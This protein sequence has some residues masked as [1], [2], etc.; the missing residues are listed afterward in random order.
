M[1][2]LILLVLAAC[3]SSTPE[4]RS[5]DETPWVSVPTEALP[6]FEGSPPKNVLMISIDTLRKDHLSRYDPL[7]RDLTPF[8]DDLMETG[9]VLDDHQTC[10][11]WTFVGV[12]CTLAGA[13]HTEIGFIPQLEPP[14]MR[15]PFRAGQEF[16]SDWMRDAGYATVLASANG[17]LSRDWGTAAGYD[18]T[19]GVAF[20]SAQ[21]IYEGGLA[22]LQE[23]IDGGAD[24]WFLHLHFLEPHAPY[25]VHEGFTPD[26]SDLP[27]VRWD[28][29]VKGQHYEATSQWGELTDAERDTLGE[30]LRRR[31]EGEVAWLD[32]VLA[33]YFADLGERGLL[34]DTLVVVWSDHGE[35]FWEKGHQ[36]HGW[37]LHRP[38]NDGVAFF[39]SPQI[40]PGA[41]SGPTHATDLVPT[42]LG[43]QGLQ[44]PPSVSGVHVGLASP[45]RPRFA[46]TVARAG[47]HQSVRRGNKKL[48]YEW[49]GPTR[50]YDLAVDSREQLGVWDPDDPEHQELWE[51][52]SPEVAA[53]LPLV[54]GFAPPAPPTWAP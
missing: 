30:H 47:V 33:G 21:T 20:D 40:V 43:L 5:V 9:F 54:E 31:Y 15:I 13:N 6:D 4:T 42:I 48:I 1:R 32:H 14:S 26:T 34:A 37:T 12:T 39:W 27:D 22:D 11:N 53:L 35:A 44:V 28:L 46:A 10:S 7:E 49:S 38:E 41:W 29:S 51:L 45:S 17:Y 52:L 18:A 16:L 50:V 3:P 19:S 24:K 36:S 8:L 23:A 25:L 2:S